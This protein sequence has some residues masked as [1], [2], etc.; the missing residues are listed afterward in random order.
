MEGW[1]K[2]SAAAEYIGLSSR[3]VR[4]LLK[5]GLKFSRLPSG[6]ILIRPRNI[7]EYIAQFEVDNNKTA[8]MIEA[9]VDR[10]IREI[11]TGI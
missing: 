10:I 11:E 3:S 2:I 5:Q 8:N 9:E 4:S 7:D 6:T 1:M